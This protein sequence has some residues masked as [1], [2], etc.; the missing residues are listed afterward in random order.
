M[1]YY[2][3]NTILFFSLFLISIKS[4]SQSI[5]V[6][7]D[8]LNKESKW[9]VKRVGSYV[10]KEGNKLKEG[11][12][13]EYDSTNLL[14]NKYLFRNGICYWDSSIYTKEDTP[15]SLK[16]INEQEDSVIIKQYWRNTKLHQYITYPY[17]NDS[18]INSYTININPSFPFIYKE[19]DENGELKQ[20]IIQKWIFLEG[21][22]GK[23]VCLKNFMLEKK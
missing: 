10:I 20:W 23:F 6:E 1:Q 7:F 15:Y 9:T 8:T 2:T 17:H 18:Q 5:V 21:Q 14:T 16:Y 3:L 22:D 13:T 12:W 4:H 19:Y 11:I